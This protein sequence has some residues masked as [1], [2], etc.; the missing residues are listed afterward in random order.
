MVTLATLGLACGLNIGGPPPPD[1]KATIQAA[2]RAAFPTATAVGI[3]LGRDDATAQA[4]KRIQTS[5]HAPTPTPAQS[6]RAGERGPPAH[7]DALAANVVRVVDGDTVDV[8]FANGSGARVRLLGV[9]TPEVFSPNVP[10]EF[11]HVSDTTCLDRWGERAAEFAT[12]SLEGR[13]VRVIPGEGAERDAAG[14]LLAFIY[15]DGRDFNI[16]LVGRG[17][18]R[19][20]T[21]G[22]SRR[23]HDYLRIQDLARSR[24][25]GLWECEAS[26]S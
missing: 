2:E 20:F 24:G 19:V 22:E 13:V 4:G 23:E 3:S 12:E 15:V 25:I 5:L 8:V 16:T 1:I 21:V 7:P 26:P 18:G 11:G 10:N 9:D 17:Y 14:R 6:A